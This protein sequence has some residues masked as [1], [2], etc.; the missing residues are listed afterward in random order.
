MPAVSKAQRRFFGWAMAHPEQA[1]SE[2]KATGMTTDQM[3]DYASTSEK[4][5]PT[6][7]RKY[8]G[9]PA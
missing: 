8:Y 6:R 3:R 1:K 4:G 2:G 9:E 7:K 5:L